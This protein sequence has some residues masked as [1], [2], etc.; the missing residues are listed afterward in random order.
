MSDYTPP[1]LLSP[2]SLRVKDAA[3]ALGVGHST[4]Y[5]LMAAGRLAYRRLGGI[6]LIDPEA[7]VACRN[8]LP[9]IGPDMT[10]TGPLLDAARQRLAVERAGD[11]PKRSRRKAKAKTKVRARARSRVAKGA[12]PAPEPPES[13]PAQLTPEL[14]PEPAPEPDYGRM[15]AE[16]LKLIASGD[17]EGRLRALEY[18]VLAC[19]RDRKC[20]L[21]DAKQFVLVAIAKAKEKV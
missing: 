20:S 9:V 6:R 14:A 15:F 3:R 10:P 8:S 12:A 18:T 1:P 13:E 4:L 19:S 7:L 16:R 11:A 17:D 21:D 5:N 2:V